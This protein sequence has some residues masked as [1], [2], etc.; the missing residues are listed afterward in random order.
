M[1]RAR[2]GRIWGASLSVLLDLQILY[3]IYEIPKGALAMCCRNVRFI[4][5]KPS[6]Y[7]LLSGPYCSMRSQF[8]IF[9]NE[10]DRRDVTWII[11]T[12][13]W[14]E[15]RLRS[16]VAGIQKGENSVT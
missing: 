10:N 11:Q 2:G 12:D 1:T 16:L 15:I 7:I 5:T 3:L 9:L 8:L 6:R 14:L 13:T 4:K